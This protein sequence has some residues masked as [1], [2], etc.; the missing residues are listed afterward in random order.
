MCQTC[1]L[2]EELCN[3]SF[4]RVYYQLSLILRPIHSTFSRTKMHDSGMDIVPSV[5]Y[6]IGCAQPQ[7]R[8]LTSAY[9]PVH[10]S[11]HA[12]SF[13]MLKPDDNSICNLIW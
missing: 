13:V 10:Q 6:Q 11:C 4:Y 7:P 9:L 12:F 5:L 1:L 2:Y 8:I 3:L